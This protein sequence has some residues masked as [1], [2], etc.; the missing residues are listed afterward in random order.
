MAFSLKSTFGGGGKPVCSMSL[1]PD[2]GVFINID[3]RVY[4]RSG[5]TLKNEAAVYPIADSVIGYTLPFVDTFTQRTLPASGGWC[6]VAYGAGVF[7]AV[8]NASSTACYTSV[9]G[10]NWITRTIP[11]LFTNNVV[12]VNGLFIISASNSA[13]ILTSVDG[14]TWVQRTLPAAVSWYEVAYGNGKYVAVASGTAI[15]A[16]STDGVTWTRGNIAPRSNWSSVAFGAGIF[17][18]VASTGYV[19]TSTDGVNWTARSSRGD[20]NP[21]KVA[22]VN[23][24]FVVV[25]SNTTGAYATSA[26]GINWDLQAFPV[27]V[28]S[29]YDI[30]GV[31]GLIIV[32]SANTSECYTSITAKTGSWVRA[33]IPIT[34]AWRGAAYGSNVLLILGQSSAVSVTAP[35]GMN[36]ILSVPPQITS[37]SAVKYMRIK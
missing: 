26:D 10:I 15:T 3:D 12:Y 6:S 25:G 4:L 11:T 33:P 13:I 37:G 29:N 8:I 23:G 35:M 5:T 16:Y 7:V 31:N 36:R 30:V 21:N 22:F 14:T 9:D 17:V 20:V 34:A 32:T 2:K 1:F 18:A 27:T 24:L 28:V 19:S